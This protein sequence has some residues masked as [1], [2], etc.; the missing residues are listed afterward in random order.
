MKNFEKLQCSFEFFQLFQSSFLP[1]CQEFSSKYFTFPELS[2]VFQGFS[3]S[4]RQILQVLPVK[5]LLIFILLILPGKIWQILF[6]FFQRRRSV[7]C[8][9]W[10]WDIK[11]MRHIYICST[12][13]LSGDSFSNILT[14]GMIFFVMS[15]DA[16]NLK[17]YKNCQVLIK[18]NSPMINFIYIRVY[19]LPNHHDL[20]LPELLLKFFGCHIKVLKILSA[21]PWSVRP[22][23]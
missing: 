4:S 1:S 5:M 7:A 6:H 22:M 21:F 11:K 23:K 2:T 13:S 8:R 10:W 20:S 19:V 12:Y 18:I 17:R 15:V 16:A 3:M 14:H 9:K